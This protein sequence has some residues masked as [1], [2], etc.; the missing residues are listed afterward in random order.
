MPHGLH[1]GSPAL[2]DSVSFRGSVP[3]WM[4]WM[5]FS[6]L[7]SLRFMVPSVY[8]TVVPSGPMAGDPMD[9][10]PARSSTCNPFN[11]N[12]ARYRNKEYLTS[13]LS[14]TVTELK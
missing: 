9:L 4:V 13:R 3:G 5:L 6:V 12:Q 2:P 11:G 1:V 10:M 14:F 8:S 7:F